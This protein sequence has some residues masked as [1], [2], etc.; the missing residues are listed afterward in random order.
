MRSNL[1]FSKH[2]TVFVAIVMLVQSCGSRPPLR[3][4]AS[5][6]GVECDVQTL[7]EYPTNISRIELLNTFSGSLVWNLRATTE[8]VQVARFSLVTGENAAVPSEV[9]QGTFRILAPKSKSTFQLEEGVE[10]ELRVWGAGKRPS[11]ERFTLGGSVP[12]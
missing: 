1:V 2:A 4:T 10:Y 5:S 3:V 7:G 12:G 6:R 9:V 11:I 8:G